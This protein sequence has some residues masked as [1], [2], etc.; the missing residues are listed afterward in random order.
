MTLYRT[1]DDLWEF[2]TVSK[3]I[4]LDPTTL[5]SSFK[6]DTL[7]SNPSEWSNNFH[8]WLQKTQPEYTP[9]LPAFV[10]V[11]EPFLNF[12]T[13]HD[14]PEFVSSYG[15]ILQYRSDIRRLAAQIHLELSQFIPSLR[16]G[17]SIR[18]DTYLG[19]HLRKMTHDSPPGLTTDWTSLATQAKLYA[20]T[21]TTYNL[22]TIYVAATR[23]GDIS[24][25]K[26]L[27]NEQGLHIVSKETLLARG[28]L[29]GLT[30]DQ[31][32]IVDFEV[33]LRG[34]GFVGVTWSLFAWSVAMRRH[35]VCGDEVEVKLE[36]GRNTTGH[37]LGFGDG[38]SRLFGERDETFRWGVW[39]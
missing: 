33:L 2:P 13:D 17:T 30:W 23:V 26:G 21:A 36:D 25:I 14:S 32:A 22:R 35:T 18:N 9:T 20:N 7:D 37:D 38:C 16:A 5:F 24:A 31:K 1:M 15:R 29:D 12:P 4:N 8:H 19:A 11:R 6:L 28:A 34:G 3:P 39:P 10:R 27:A